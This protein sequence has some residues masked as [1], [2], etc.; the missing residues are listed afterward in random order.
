MS[1]YFDKS[2]HR[3]MVEE[4][5]RWREII[6]EIPY[7]KFHQDWLVSV[8]PPFGGS[9]AR[10]R[11][12]L[13]S[14]NEKSVYLDFYD[15]LGYFGSPYWEVYPYRGDCGRAALNDTNLLVE[16]IGDEAE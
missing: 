12:R 15:R 13:P 4:D 6:N 10:F 2:I 3:S 16:M 1:E 11:V 8:I 7:I 14:G 9:V 5:E